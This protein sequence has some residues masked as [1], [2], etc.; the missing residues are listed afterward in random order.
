MVS[1]HVPLTQPWEPE[2]RFALCQ[3]LQSDQSLNE[4]LPLAVFI[5]L[6]IK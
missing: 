2:K 4:V 6:P 5:S 3:L 1:C